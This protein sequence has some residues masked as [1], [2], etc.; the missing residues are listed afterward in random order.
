LVVS[1]SPGSIYCNGSLQVFSQ[2]DVALQP[3]SS[4]LIFLD[5]IS[6]R[7]VSVATSTATTFGPQVYPIAVVT[8]GIDRVLSLTDQRP[9]LFLGAGGAWNSGDP[10]HPPR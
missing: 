4:V 1:I 8:T 7:Q 5:L 3:N 10:A 2:Q 9:D 6:N